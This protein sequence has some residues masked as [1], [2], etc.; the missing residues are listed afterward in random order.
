MRVVLAC[1]GHVWLGTKIG[2]PCPRCGK[3]GQPWSWTP[4]PK[5]RGLDD[6]NQ[7]IVGRKK[8]WVEGFLA[9]ANWL[10]ESR[11]HM[12]GYAAGDVALFKFNLIR[13]RQLRKVKQ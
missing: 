1:H 4:V 11:C 8:R 3:P 12:N 6:L 5:A 7:R 13:K 2:E 10:S 9:C